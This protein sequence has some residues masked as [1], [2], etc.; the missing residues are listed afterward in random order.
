MGSTL[1]LDKERDRQFY[2]LVA[3]LVAILIFFYEFP[4]F[5][6]FKVLIAVSA[7]YAEANPDP[8]ALTPPSTG[9]THIVV[10]VLLFGSVV[11]VFLRPRHFIRRS[12]K[13]R[14]THY[15]VFVD[16]QLLEEL[17]L[18]NTIDLEVKTTN[19]R[20]RSFNESSRSW[21]T[22][23]RSNLLVRSVRY[24]H[25]VL[26]DRPNSLFRKHNRILNKIEAFFSN[27]NWK[28]RDG[29]VSG[30]IAAD[31]LAEEQQLE[32]KE[33]RVD[34]TLSKRSRRKP[35]VKFSWG[36]RVA[37]AAIFSG[38]GGAFWFIGKFYIVGGIFFGLSA[39]LLGDLI[40]T[41]LGFGQ[42]PTK[43]KD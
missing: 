30:R 28:D 9:T 36:A 14:T 43:H 1:I 31:V 20:H 8:A 3:S 24:P 12:S 6:F 40:L 13:D 27:V 32:E 39:I 7:Q 34:K 18:E 11:W 25:I 5:W 33:K 21:T 29:V 17:E 42:Q 2:T 10:L 15:H 38:F 4:L 41:M 26:Y 37:M 35:E 23:H 19:Q 16:G 22:Q